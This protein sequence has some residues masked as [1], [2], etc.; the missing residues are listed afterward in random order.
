MVISKKMANVTA[1][2]AASSKAK[3]SL[4]PRAKS[5]SSA[6]TTAAPVSVSAAGKTKKATNVVK[7]TVIS[8]KKILSTAKLA[9]EKVIDAKKSPAKQGAKKS[10]ALQVELKKSTMK[11]SATKADLKKHAAAKETGS[12]KTLKQ[13]KEKL[14]RDSFTMPESEYAVL[15]EV[16]KECLSKGVEV[17][18][19]QLL[20][21]GL[22]LLKT[23]D[24]NQVQAQLENLPE[25]KAGRPKL[26][27]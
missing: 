19:S 16:K 25:L 15:G 4:N 2:G 8:E 27:K 17:K 1:K 11:R 23:L 20:R 22:A 26:N 14:V 13:K 18:K 24:V 6:K 21:I 12:T 9:V 5:T 10:N 7:P 3:A